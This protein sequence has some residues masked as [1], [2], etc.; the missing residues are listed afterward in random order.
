M[1]AV[2]AVENFVEEEAVPVIAGALPLL[3]QLVQNKYI[4]G[5]A[6][7]AEK[8]AADLLSTW[9]SSAKFDLPSQVKIADD[10]ADTIEDAKFGK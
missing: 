1:S 8:A 4:E 3:V 6:T 9:F 2:D 10:A 5:L 7:D